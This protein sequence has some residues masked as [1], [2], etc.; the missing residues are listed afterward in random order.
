[1]REPGWLPLSH[2]VRD[3]ENF[4]RGWGPPKAV[5]PADSYFLLQTLVGAWPAA[6]VDEA[7]ADRIAQWCEKYLREAKL[8]SSWA[9]PA[10]AYEDAFKALAR[11]LCLADAAGPFRAHLERC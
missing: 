11:E 5:D 3:W 4:V 9:T 2:H 1:M 8:R 7:F 6:Q 10:V